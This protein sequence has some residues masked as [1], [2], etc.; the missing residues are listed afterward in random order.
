M[1]KVIDVVK[2]PL[3]KENVIKSVKTSPSKFSKLKYVLLT[4]AIMLILYLIVEV[5]LLAD[6][7]I[8][9]SF[10]LKFGI[11]APLALIFLQIFQSMISIIPSQIT[12]IAAGY[13]FGP[14]LGLIYSL[15]GS[16]IGSAI[17]FLISRKYGEKLALKFFPKKEISHFHTFFKQKRS[18]ALFLARIAPIFPNDLVSF[19][20]GLTRIKFLKF[21]LISS[22]GFLVQIMILSY[23]GSGLAKGEVNIL[24]IIISILVGILLVIVLF[25]KKIK[26]LI[27]KDLKEFEEEIQKNVKIVF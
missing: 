2:E 12:T 16:F 23:F 10:I 3:K 26:E 24:V 22:L 27:I 6:P 19:S 17:I 9:R 8:I 18:Q 7:E 25:K 1:K 21:N 5:S 15:I 20:A 13:I 4:V 11:L 14:I